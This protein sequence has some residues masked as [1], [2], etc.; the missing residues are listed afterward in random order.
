MKEKKECPD[1]GS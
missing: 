1:N